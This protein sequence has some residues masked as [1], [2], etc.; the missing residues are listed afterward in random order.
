MYPIALAVSVA[1]LAVG[2]VTWWRLHRLQR[3]VRTERAAV[4]VTEEAYHH[5]LDVFRR[6]IGAA[7]AKLAEAEAEQ[8]LL[9]D[10]DRIVAAEYAR[11]THNPHEGEST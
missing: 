3:L 10:V 8:L 1:L 9:A 6:R 4:R 2:A 11:A 7:M 5:D